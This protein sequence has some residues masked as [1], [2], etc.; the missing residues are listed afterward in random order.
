MTALALM[1]LLLRPGR[2]EA[3]K[4]TVEGSS[5]LGLEG[6]EL[7]QLRGNRMAMILGS[8]TQR[9]NRIKDML[10]AVGLREDVLERFPHQISGG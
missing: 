2:V 1:G 9:R 8:A 10:L 5:L 6:A 7:R 4:V 3:D